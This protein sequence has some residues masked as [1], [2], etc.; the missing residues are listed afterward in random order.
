[1]SKM[2]AVCENHRRMAHIGQQLRGQVTSLR[3]SSPQEG[4]S[5]NLYYAEELGEK[6]E[7]EFYG[8]FGLLKSHNN[9]NFLHLFTKGSLDMGAH[10]LELT[11]LAIS[12][13][14]QSRSNDIW[15]QNDA[16]LGLNLWN[17]MFLTTKLSAS[18]LQ[19]L[20]QSTEIGRMMRVWLEEVDNNSLRN[21][22]EQISFQKAIQPWEQLREV[23]S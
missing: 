5:Q 20:V 6:S 17:S 8:R 22:V 15:R 3:G 19:D 1:M 14:F 13:S 18:S 9:N 23:I 11:P 21:K 12:L 16:Y 7:V 2:D 10:P 4:V